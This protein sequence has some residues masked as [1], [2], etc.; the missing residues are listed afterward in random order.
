MLYTM[1]VL[2]RSPY[3]FVTSRY[4]FKAVFILYHFDISDLFHVSLKRTKM[5]KMGP[6]LLILRIWT[7]I[8]GNM[9]N[10][11]TIDEAIRTAHHGSPTKLFVW[12]MR[13]L[14]ATMAGSIGSS[15]KG[16]WSKYLASKFIRRLYEITNQVQISGLLHWPGI[17]LLLLRNLTVWY[18]RGP[19]DKRN[20]ALDGKVLKSFE[21]YY[22]LT[23]LIINVFINFWL[24]YQGTYCLLIESVLS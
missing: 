13:S 4:I 16:T 7:K 8:R 6:N 3:C 1:T 17:L 21:P 24:V 20:W 12:I 15:Q 2:N 22:S 9:V 23:Q 19:F 11:I 10:L 5:G 18:E 14:M